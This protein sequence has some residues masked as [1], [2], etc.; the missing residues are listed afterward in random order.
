[1]EPLAPISAGAA[2][3]AVVAKKIDQRSPSTSDA[4]GEVVEHGL[5]PGQELI[6]MVGR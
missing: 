5:D 1:M 3:V 4:R 2:V 6:P